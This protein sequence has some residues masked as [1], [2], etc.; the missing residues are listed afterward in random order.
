MQNDSIMEMLT[1]ISQQLESV[2]IQMDDMQKSIET[3]QKE[4]LP[5][6]GLASFAG[7]PLSSAYQ[8]SSKNLIPKFKPGKR[9]LFKREDIVAYI[10]KHRIASKSEIHARAIN[11]LINGGRHDA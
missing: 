8:I 7:I 2:Q 11:S 9:V 1:K 5:M 10:E 4:Y 3:G 6:K